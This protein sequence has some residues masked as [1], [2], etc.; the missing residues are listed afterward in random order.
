MQFLCEIFLLTLFAV[1][2]S[3][4]VVK[5]VVAFSMTCCPGLKPDFFNA[6]TMTFL[7]LLTIA[8]SLLAG[9]YPQRSYPDICR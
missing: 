4:L 2:L 1:I 9:F 7:F 3:M 6:D 5:P 8:T